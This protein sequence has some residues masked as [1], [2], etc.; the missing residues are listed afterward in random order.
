M[1][2]LSSPIVILS[3]LSLA[4]VQS[5]ENL[6]R[7]IRNALSVVA[8]RWGLQYHNVA[9]GTSPLGGASVLQDCYVDPSSQQFGVVN[10]R[11][12]VLQ[13]PVSQ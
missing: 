11:I 6:Q 4:G 2:L 7:E 5:Q 3:L 1:T 12:S 8:Q 10:N 9:L 13:N